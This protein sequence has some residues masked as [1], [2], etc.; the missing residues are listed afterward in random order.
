MSVFRRLAPALLLGLLATGCGSNKSVSLDA[1]VEGA[2]LS[3]TDGALGTQIGGG[4]TLVL[5]LGHYASKSTQVTVE[6]FS[7]LG[8]DSNSTALA[9]LVVGPDPGKIDVGVGKKKSIAFTVDGT[10]LL[11]AA[12]K[13]A[14]CAGAVVIVGTVTDTLGG[15]KSI[16]LR[17]ARFSVS[18]C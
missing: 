2:N 7:V 1:R 8:A 17:S 4:F 9:P 14:L 13:T 10:K 3:L 18:G 15:G 5:E 16:P 12:D 6:S 11:T